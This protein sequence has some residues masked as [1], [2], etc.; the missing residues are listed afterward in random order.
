M[1]YEQ[2]TSNAAVKL[3]RLASFD[4]EQRMVSYIRGRIRTLSDA[5][6]VG[7]YLAGDNTDAI[8]LDANC[9]PDTVLYLV[10]RAGHKPRPRGPRSDK[11]LLITD[12]EIIRLYRSGLSGPVI[13]AKA[14]TTPATIYGR[15]RRYNVPRRPPGDVSKAIAAATKARRSR[16]EQPP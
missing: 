9:T 7:R 2:L 4:S 11:T 14:G 3:L 12:D 10:R 15:L 1:Q 8:G 16:K 5:E 6:I 13:A